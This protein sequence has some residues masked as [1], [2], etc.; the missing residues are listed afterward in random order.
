MPSGFITYPGIPNPKE[1]IATRCTGTSPSTAILYAVPESSSPDTS[2]NATLSFGFN[3]VTINWTGCLL[4]IGTLQVTAA[5]QQQI[6]K[7]YDRRWRWS[8]AWIVGAY[9]LILPDGTVDADTQQTI[10]QLVSKLFTQIGGETVDTSLITS[11]EYPTVIWD[12]ANCADELDDLLTSRG[13]VICLQAD[14]TVKIY[15]RDTGATLPANGDVVNVSVSINPPEVPLYLTAVGARTLVQSKLMCE[16]VGED[17]DGTIKLVKDLTYNPG[18]VSNATGWDNVDMTTFACITDVDA[19][20]RALKTVGKWFQATFQGDGSQHITDGGANNYVP[21][22]ITVDDA[23]QLYPL[24]NHLLSSHDNQFGKKQYDEAYVEIVAYD[25]WGTPPK[26]EN[27]PAFTR[28][29]QRDWKLIPEWG[30]VVFNEPLLKKDSGNMVFGDC[31]LT[32]S[33]SI[34]STATGRIKDRYIRQKTLGGTGEDVE[35]VE[36]LQRT[37]KVAYTPGTATVASI[38]DNKTTVDT[39]ADLFLNAAALKYSANVGTLALYRGI[40]A[41]NTDGVALQMVWNCA[42]QS[43]TPWSTYVAQYCE[44]LP[45]LPT[46]RHRNRNRTVRRMPQTDVTRQENYIARRKHLNN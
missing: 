29:D 5:G 45:R 26:A 8:K 15:P 30:I 37:I 40:Y 20:E 33:Y 4:D 13:Y 24:N 2:G 23:K 18:G 1:L 17:K 38:T 41:F 7:I 3:G 39:A 34:D 9:N 32:C 12:H 25:T 22:E 10:P 31:Y 16:A 42:V 44:A 19:R 36:Q 35:R 43:D 6:F 14:N 27:T 46:S 28:I 11:T 21:G